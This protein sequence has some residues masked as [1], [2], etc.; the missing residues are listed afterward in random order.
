MTTFSKGDKVLIKHMSGDTAVHEDKHLRV[1][2][3]EAYVS[4]I[5]E[6]SQAVFLTIPTHTYYAKQGSY[7]ATAD[8]VEL[9]E[10]AHHLAKE[11]QT[12]KV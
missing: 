3:A 8:E 12:L 5:L 11:P 4:S 6:Q 1:V 7:F 2:G 9:A 10:G